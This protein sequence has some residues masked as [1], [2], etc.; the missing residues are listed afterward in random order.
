M[1]IQMNMYKIKTFIYVWT[2]PRLTKSTLTTASVVYKT[3]SHKHTSNTNS[4]HTRFYNSVLECT[5]HDCWCTNLKTLK[6]TEP[7]LEQKRSKQSSILNH[8]SVFSQ[9]GTSTHS[10]NL[11]NCVHLLN[12]GFRV[13]IDHNIT[14]G[15]RN[16]TGVGSGMRCPIRESHVAIGQSSWSGRGHMI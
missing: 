7:Q 8:N 13:H 4:I 3:G 10:I 12:V 11:D 5:S 15:M 1:L 6:Q 2:K 16:G 9:H 14:W